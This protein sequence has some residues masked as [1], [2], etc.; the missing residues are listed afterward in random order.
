MIVASEPHKYVKV[1]EKYVTDE[2]R[3]VS[4]ADPDLETVDAEVGGAE[5]KV[6][7]YMTAVTGILRIVSEVEAIEKSE[8]SDEAEADK[9][10][11]D[12]AVVSNYDQSSEYKNGSCQLI[13]NGLYK[14]L[15]DLL[16]L[17]LASKWS[18]LK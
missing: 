12:R 17:N 6:V 14:L 18:N 8:K 9:G 5:N 4:I 15:N 16:M 7:T 3:L 2:K 13:L 10:A 11:A 1:V